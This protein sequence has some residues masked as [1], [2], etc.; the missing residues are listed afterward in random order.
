VID[1]EVLESNRRLW[2]TWTER[3]ASSEFY[4]LEAFLGGA[5]SLRRIELEE[6]GEEIAGRRLLHLQ[7]HFGLDT[8]SWARL[9]AE[10]TGMDLSP[11]AVELAH[12]LSQQAKIPARFIESDL[13]ALPSVLKEPESF[14]IV[15]TSYGAID[16]LCDLKRWGE[17]IAGYLKPGGLF[18][19]VEFHP[20][21]LMLGED[22]RTIKFPYFPQN[23]A[24]RTEEKGSYGA[25][26]EEVTGVSYAWSHSLS[27][28]LEALLSAG[29]RLEFLHEFPY[30][31]YDCFPFTAEQ[32]PGYATVPGLEGQIPLAW[33]V[34]AVKEGS[35]Q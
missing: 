22:G 32:E 6:L 13:Y 15:Y 16:W 30:S 5:T 8:L 25:P 26:G 19:M 14:D 21:A 1:P 33:S 18:Y 31:P 17:I 24:I 27:E 10:V 20:L 3:H 29:L 28:V 7:C 4:D 9:G 34:R 35:S 11:K 2:D 12:R 23:E